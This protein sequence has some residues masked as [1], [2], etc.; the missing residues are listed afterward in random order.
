MLVVEVVLFLHRRARQRRGEVQLRFRVRLGH[1]EGRRGSDGL[2]K[3]TNATVSF[4]VAVVIVVVVV[5]ATVGIAV[6]VVVAVTVVVVVAVVVAVGL[7]FLMLPFLMLLLFLLYDWRWKLIVKGKGSSNHGIVVVA[8]IIV[9][10]TIVCSDFDVAVVVLANNGVVKGSMGTVASDAA[11]A[12][13]CFLGVADAVVAVANHGE[14]GG[15]V[16]GG[17]G[18]VDHNPLVVATA[19]TKKSRVG[20][21]VVGS[22]AVLL[23]RT[24]GIEAAAIP[25]LAATEVLS[26]DAV[27]AVVAADAADAGRGGKG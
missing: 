15:S 26:V 10:V 7:L 12:A 11:A 8:I 3:V 25:S 24:I 2:Q 9:V 23:H 4:A 13:V 27:D 22:S 16:Q 20:G 6:V 5:T 19:A 1:A 21:F 17:A 14:Q 18:K